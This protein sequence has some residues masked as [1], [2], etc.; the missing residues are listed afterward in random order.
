MFERDRWKIRA[1]S[2]KVSFLQGNLRQVLKF[3]PGRLEAHI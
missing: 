1:K 3:C 2:E